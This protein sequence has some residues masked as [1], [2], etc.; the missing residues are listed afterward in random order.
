MKEEVNLFPEPFHCKQEQIRVKKNGS[1]IVP[2][3]FLPFELG[4]HKCYVVFSDEA[5]GEMQYTII[6]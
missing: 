6:G 3:T 2:I 4:V 1:A 5:V